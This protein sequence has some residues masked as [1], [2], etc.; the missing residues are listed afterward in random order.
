M[1]GVVLGLLVLQ[2]L[3][4]NLGAADKTWVGGVS[5]NW[6]EPANWDPAGVPVPTD[7]IVITNPAT[8]IITG[9][10]VAA[11]LEV[12]HATLVVSNQ[13]TV[14]NLLLADFARLS[15]WIT[16]PTPF[17]NPPAGSG[18]VEVPASGRLGIGPNLM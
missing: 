11:S 1:R 4:A 15:A 7:S 3:S 8:V 6:F 10:V 2:G 16:R 18:I 17:T 5:S 9:N 14:T 13:L 12:R